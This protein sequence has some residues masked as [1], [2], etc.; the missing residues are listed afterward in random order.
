MSK[1]N[2]SQD[3]HSLTDFKRNTS[4]FLTHLRETKHPL[5]LTVNGKAELVIQDS[6]SYQK[7]IDAAELLE[8]LQ[9]IKNGLEQMKQ[10]EGKKGENFFN[11]LFEKLDSSS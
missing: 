3:I 8:T 10:G 2:L 9:G 5:V 7:L 6:E 4:Q 1:I 11:E